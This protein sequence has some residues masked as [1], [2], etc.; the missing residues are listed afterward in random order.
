M[1]KCSASGMQATPV[2]I[3]PADFTMDD[4]V[5]VDFDLRPAV[6]G[7]ERMVGLAL[8]RHKALVA[9]VRFA[10]V[11]V[12]QDIQ[13]A[14]A[15]AHGGVLGVL[16]Q[17]DMAVVATLLAGG[18]AR[19]GNL[20]A[21]VAR[22]GLLAVMTAP[23]STL[24]TRLQERAG[25]AAAGGP[26]DGGVYRR[27]G[28]LAVAP[29]AVL[30]GRTGDRPGAARIFRPLPA[31]HRAGHGRLRGRRSADTLAAAGRQHDTARPVHSGRRRER[32]DTADYR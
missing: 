32:P 21:V 13:M 19:D 29:P 27:P 26:V 1:L 31:D 22:G 6:S 7:G 24:E 16:H 5:G 4:G 20:H 15:L 23:R 12:E 10:D 8:G 18:Q 14:V 11:I 25:G 9:P 28:G 30:A 17:P 2:K 3:T